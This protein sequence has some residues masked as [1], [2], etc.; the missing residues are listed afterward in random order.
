MASRDSKPV[1]FTREAAERISRVVNTVEGD[2]YSLAAPRSRRAATPWVTLQPASVTT[3]IPT[4]TLGSPSS[5]GRATIYRDDGSGGLIAAETAA[6]V[7]NYHTLSA[8][9]AVGK[10]ISVYW[11][12][13]VWWLVASDC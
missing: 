5:T 8:S 13:G 4:G 12:D 7:K 11:R 3:A 6:T 9:I 2:G 10:T 1:T